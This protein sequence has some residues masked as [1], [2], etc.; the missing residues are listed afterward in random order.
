VIVVDQGDVEF[1]NAEQK[2]WLLLEQFQL[3]EITTRILHVDNDPMKEVP[4]HLTN[5]A[6]G[7]I[8]TETD[9]LT[10]KERPQ[11]THYQALSHELDPSLAPVLRVGLRGQAKISAQPQTW[12]FIRQTF[13]FKL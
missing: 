6:G 12:R 13:N 10:G 7:E 3:S 8:A 2:V 5:K 11:S 1:V 4:E 9:P